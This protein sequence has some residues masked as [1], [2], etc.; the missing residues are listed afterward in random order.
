MTY[1][2]H[3]DGGGNRA[4]ANALS[5]SYRACA[6][7][8]SY[9]L[10]DSMNEPVCGNIENL[11]DKVDVLPGKL[12]RDSFFGPWTRMNICGPPDRSTAQGGLCH[13]ASARPVTR[14]NRR[15]LPD[16]STIIRVEPP[17]RWQNAPSGRT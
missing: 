12:C 16:S 8:S 13:E 4:A 7:A 9:I 14:P 10:T 2:E 11:H 17:L 3:D 6:C 1:T 5:F 15:Q